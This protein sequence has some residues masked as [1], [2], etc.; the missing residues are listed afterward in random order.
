MSKNVMP[1]CFYA[2]FYI[3]WFAGVAYSQPFW[4]SVPIKTIFQADNGLK[5][6]EGF[7][8]VMDIKYS[9]SNSDV[10]Y[11]ATDRSQVWKSVDGGKVWHH[12]SNGILANGVRSLAISPIDHNVIFAA[13]FAGDSFEQTK[14]RIL[15][16][17]HSGLY[18]S[19]NGGKNW[20]FV[21]KATFYKQRS[22]GSLV[23]FDSSDHS[24]N[25]LYFGDY[26][27]GLFK[28]SNGGE[29]WSNC[30]LPWN[31]IIDIEEDPKQRGVFYILTDKVF[32]KFDGKLA[33]EL[34][35]PKDVNIHSI[36]LG[37]VDGNKVLYLATNE[38]GVYISTDD[39]FSF[40]AQKLSSHT[41]GIT[42]IYA[43][44]VDGKILFASKNEAA[45]KPI[46]SLDGGKSWHL[47]E[48]INYRSL[49]TYEGFWFSYPVA[50]HPTKQNIAI[51]SSNGSDQ[52]LISKDT[53]TTWQYSG[54]GYTGGLMSD[55]IFINNSEAFF[56]LWDFGLWKTSDFD[57]FE[58]CKIKRIYGQQSSH[59]GDA[60]GDVV[61]ASVGQWYKKC[62][63]VS[64]DRGATWEYHLDATYN[65][66]F[67]SFHKQD[68]SVVYAGPYISYDKGSSWKQLEY[69]VL[70]IFVND[71]D[72]IYSK[73]GAASASDVLIS[74]DRGRNWQAPWPS[75]PCKDNHINDIVVGNYENDVLVATA[76]GIFK[77]S[78]NK[79]IKISLKSGFADDA[80]GFNFVNDLAVDPTN[81]DVVYA[82][83]RNPGVG[84]SNGVFMSKDFGNTWV[85]INYNL[86]KNLTVL[87]VKTSLS[88]DLFI[89]THRGTFRLNIK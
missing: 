17:P 51:I 14:S 86:G 62:L 15:F 10:L 80:F 4:Q 38:N 24:G 66:N 19:V 41:N 21:K 83:R 88:G 61:V 53:G 81:R 49:S 30:E 71:S 79:W 5:G 70:A 69:P 6:G 67:I 28:T 68:H 78:D 54:T 2:I 23:V 44:P 85:N 48:D 27:D 37:I 7:Q 36:A 39:G 8:H 50:L 26:D 72:V 20:D 74:Y 64:R 40:I 16:R 63:A 77:L 35:K 82:A 13:G 9:S 46:I 18:R 47:S 60:Y 59:C 52:I 87:A 22:K 1:Y 32:I 29:S 33:V 42:D 73:R 76:I 75:L 45:Q 57:V 58:K 3:F 65:F 12:V 43:S 56:C 55:I 89:G 31:H 11:M 84:E 25:T 34:N